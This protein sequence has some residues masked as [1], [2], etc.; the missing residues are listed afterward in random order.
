MMRHADK[1]GLAEIHDPG[2]GGELEEF[3][4]SVGHK[5]LATNEHEFAQMKI[6]TS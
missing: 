1:P 2:A 4:K 6:K 3:P 5:V